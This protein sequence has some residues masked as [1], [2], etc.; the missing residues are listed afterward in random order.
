MTDKSIPKTLDGLCATCKHWRGDHEKAKNMLL[1]NYESMLLIDCYQV[2]GT[3]AE[4]IS[5]MYMEI[6]GDACVTAH[7]N[8]NFGCN[9][10]SKKDD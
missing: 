10:W 4:S 9:R 6:D 8:A 3:C 7:F 2:E 5:F 1:L